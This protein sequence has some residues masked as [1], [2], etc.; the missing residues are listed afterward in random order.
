MKRYIA[1]RVL[2][3]V[4]VLNILLM[5]TS[6]TRVKDNCELKNLYGNTIYNLQNGGS[7]T[8]QNN[9]IFFVFKD[10]R[11][12]KLMVYNK[13]SLE[14]RTLK[15]F[16]SIPSELNAY[17]KYLFYKKDI[18]M[19]STSGVY[20]LNTKTKIEKAI[21]NHSVDKYIIYDKNI[22]YTISSQSDAVIEGLYR[23]DINGKNET[24]LITGKILEFVISKNNIY[25]IIENQ[26]MHHNIIN[27]KSKAVINEEKDR[28]YYDLNLYDGTL[29][30][31][32]YNLHDTL[33]DEVYKYDI[34]NH[35]IT[36]ILNGI[37]AS[38]RFVDKSFL[39]FE[40]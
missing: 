1:Y 20:R 24:L 38:L 40:N 36:I 25:Y 15:T 12:N 2:L 39:I 34:S 11:K 9:N 14:T 5:S 4:F 33:G 21:I 31:V 10:G 27:G 30:F 18:A 37:K 29:Y 19:S 8:E 3:I 35:K 32:S 7:M 28:G 26:I 16:L 17:D 23:S 6:C 13:T 22:Y